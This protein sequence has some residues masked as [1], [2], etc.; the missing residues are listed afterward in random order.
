[1]AVNRIFPAIPVG[2][3]SEPRGLEG[4]V[5]KFVWLSKHVKDTRENARRE[6]KEGSVV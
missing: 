1:M 6:A 5:T 4:R 3:I 2:G